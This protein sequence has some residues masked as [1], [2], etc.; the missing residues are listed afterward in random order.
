[1]AQK[2]K[3]LPNKYEALSSTL[4]TAKNKKKRRKV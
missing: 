3:R 2:V 4:I 1:V